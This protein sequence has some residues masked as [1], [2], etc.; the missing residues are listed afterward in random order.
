MDVP[1]NYWV[2]VLKKVGG[3]YDHLPGSPVSVVIQWPGGTPVINVIVDGRG[4]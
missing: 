3:D 4:I 2:E 1:S